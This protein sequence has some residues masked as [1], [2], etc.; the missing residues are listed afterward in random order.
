MAAQ[1]ILYASPTC[2]YCWEVR[3]YLA[4][5]QTAFVELNIDTSIDAAK[6]VQKLAGDLVVPVSVILKES[7]SPQVVI[8]FNQ[9]KLDKALEA[10]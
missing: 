2:E 10:K 6:E 3:Q 7:H 1:V 5:K 8:G 4:K 9:P